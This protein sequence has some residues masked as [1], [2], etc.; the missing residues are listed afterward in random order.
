MELGPR[1]RCG[2]T[3]TSRHRKLQIKHWSFLHVKVAS[4]CIKLHLKIF[5]CSSVYCRHY[6]ERRAKELK[7]RKNIFSTIVSDLYIPS[8]IPKK[9]NLGR[10]KGIG[11][12]IKLCGPWF[13]GRVCSWEGLLLGYALVTDLESRGEHH[14]YSSPRNT[15]GKSKANFSGKK[16]QSTPTKTAHLVHVRTERRQRDKAGSRW[17]DW[18]A[19]LVCPGTKAALLQCSLPLNPVPSHFHASRRDAE[20]SPPLYMWTLIESDSNS[21]G[22]GHSYSAPAPSNGHCSPV[23]LYYTS[24]DYPVS[25][26]WKG[27][28]DAELLQLVLNLCQ[29]PLSAKPVLL[30]NNS[31]VGFVPYSFLSLWWPCMI[32]RRHG[33]WVLLLVVLGCWGLR[34]GILI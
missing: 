11:G 16:T 8:R 19:E 1:H 18:P 26:I 7:R 30:V 28:T 15:C 17:G 32:L 12:S 27:D 34:M 22:E 23:S 31:T 4:R 9:A 25:P 6:S 13:P 10:T 21:L 20:A 3:P 29:L 5:S 2:P 33:T 14:K 24:P